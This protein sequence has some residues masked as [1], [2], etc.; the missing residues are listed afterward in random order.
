MKRFAM[1]AVCVGMMLGAGSAVAQDGA[2]EKPVEI[3]TEDL[4]TK[5]YIFDGTTLE[6]G[7]LSPGG[8]MVGSRGVTEFGS[9]LMIS[10]SFLVRIPNTVGELR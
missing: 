5:F 9:R 8:M 1:A 6:G 4:K 2:E 7:V 10:R 3:A